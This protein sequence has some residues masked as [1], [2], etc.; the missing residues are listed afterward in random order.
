[1]SHIGNVQTELDDERALRYAIELL[2]QQHPGVRLELL[3]NTAPRFYYS[4]VETIARAEN[5]VCPIVLKL[6]GKY[7][8][9]F[10]RNEQGKYVM[11]S[12][13]ELMSGSFGAD[14]AGR[15]LLGDKAAAVLDAY[16]QAKV[17]LMLMDQG[18]SFTRDVD[19]QGNVHYLTDDPTE[20]GLLRQ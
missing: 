1:M 14:D 6:P 9:G 5:R 2:I 11:I 19:A 10:Y 15:K 7:D 18:L 20:A 13:T 8:L 16:D 4:A 12:D 3:E 17:E